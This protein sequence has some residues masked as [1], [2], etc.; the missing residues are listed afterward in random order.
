MDWG[1]VA[2]ILVGLAIV[3]AGSISFAISVAMIVD[4]V[5]PGVTATSAGIVTIAAMQIATLI[6]TLLVAANHGP[7]LTVLGLRLPDATPWTYGV[8]AVVTGLFMAISAVLAMTVFREQFVVDASAFVT[9]LQADLA[10]VAIAAVLIG[11]PVTEELAIRGFAFGGLMR[12]G[13][14]L[15]WSMLITNLVWTALHAGYSSLGLTEVFLAGIILTLAYRLTGSLYVPI[16]IHA[17]YNAMALGLMSA[18]GLV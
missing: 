16:A 2:K 13:M 4:G 9:M 8:I 3:I 11:A 7:I 5:A 15:G 14:G 18:T 6:F 1:A 10:P 12:A 17:L